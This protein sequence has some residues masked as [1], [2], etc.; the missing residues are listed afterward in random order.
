VNE[1]VGRGNRV[2]KETDPDP[3][4]RAILGSRSGYVRS[5][6]RWLLSDP[7]V[8]F[9]STLLNTAAQA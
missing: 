1:D 7:F 5:A 8:S 3:N 6:D 2:V 9:S 4:E